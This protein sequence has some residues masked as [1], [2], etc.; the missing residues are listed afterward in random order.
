MQEI[1]TDCLY[2]PDDRPSSM[3]VN[4]S[5]RGQEWTLNDT[6]WS[7]DRLTRLLASLSPV[8][9]RQAS[10]HEAHTSRLYYSALS[11]PGAGT[12]QWPK[13]AICCG[14]G[15]GRGSAVC[16][17]KFL[18]LASDPSSPNAGRRTVLSLGRYLSH[19]LGPVS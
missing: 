17:R 18:G 19:H 11:L 16:G 12:E 1:I 4:C 5:L 3:Q 15:G 8:S 2:A 14:P 7:L 9:P 13:R 10:L 6:T